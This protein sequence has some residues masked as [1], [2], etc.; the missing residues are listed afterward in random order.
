MQS[1][2]EKPFRLEWQGHGFQQVVKLPLERM[3]LIEAPQVAEIIEPEPIA[4]ESRA[5]QQ[6]TAYALPV[7]VAVGV[8]GPLL[9]VIGSFLIGLA[10][11]AIAAGRVAGRYAA[12]IFLGGLAV[13]VVIAAFRLL[14][15]PGRRPVT[16]PDYPAPR[17]PAGGNITVNIQQNF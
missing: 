15:R 11:G 3:E 6:V 9:Y 2:K 12:I 8:V 17:L 13:V 10:E 1:E 16:Y 7:M 5:W 14:L 4:V